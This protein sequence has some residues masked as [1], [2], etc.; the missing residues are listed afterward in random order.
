M[1]NNITKRSFKKYNNINILKCAYS[2]KLIENLNN[3]TKSDL[4]IGENIL[5][6]CIGLPIFFTGLRSV[7][8]NHVVTIY[9][10]GKPTGY[11]T[12]GLN[13]ALP[14]YKM[15]KH[16][17]GDITINNNKMH[18]TDANK[19]P[20]ILSTFVTY[21]VIN[22]VNNYVNLPIQKIEN[23]NDDDDNDDNN[24]DDDKNKNKKEEKE[25]LVL[26]NLLE[27]IIRKEISKYTYDE[28]TTQCNNIGND[29]TDKIN[30]D[31]KSSFY[32][33]EVTNA[34]I[35]QINYSPGVEEVM[36]VKQRVKATLD[37]RKEIS[38]ATL[39]MITD[40]SDNLDDKLTEEDKSKLITCLTISMIG[41]QTPTPVI[42]IT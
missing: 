37:A 23:N 29:I 36:L 30:S 34:G 4:T 16:F 21:N 2:S 19:N 32:G 5:K 38:K 22:P 24:D 20:I 17:C 18:I 42:N 9:R 10:F 1:L 3:T 15:K 39:N 27:N 14:F 28:L 7:K 25:N 33:I 13:Y 11:L 12:E 8:K 26:K 40:I 31:E 35:L 6:Y 41:N